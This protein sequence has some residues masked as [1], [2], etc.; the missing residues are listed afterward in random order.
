MK[1]YIVLTWENH[2]GYNAGGWLK[3]CCE[4]G[5][6]EYERF[7][8]RGDSCGVKFK[9][10]CQSDY[11]EWNSDFSGFGFRKEG[12]TLTQSLFTLSI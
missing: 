3:P 2:L 10:F 11:S 4:E 6:V 12:G 5:E 7:R 1:G 8:M 9:G